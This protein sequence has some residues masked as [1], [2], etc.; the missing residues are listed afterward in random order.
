MASDLIAMVDKSLQDLREDVRD[1]RAHMASEHAALSA[2]VSDMDKALSERLSEL[3]DRVL[4]LEHQE[5]LHRIAWAVG[6]TALGILIRE[7]IGRWL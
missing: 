1:L 2:K 4:K 7:V 6:G 3:S 5:K